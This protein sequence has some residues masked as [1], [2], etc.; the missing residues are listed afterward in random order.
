MAKTI[1]PTLAA[2]LRAES[3]HTRDLDYPRDVKA[4]HP[5]RAKVYSVRLSAERSRRAS[6][7]WQKLATCPHPHWCAPGSWTGW[8]TRRSPDARL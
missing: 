6:R 4:A 8:T 3:E 5:N 2:R 7:P 1:D